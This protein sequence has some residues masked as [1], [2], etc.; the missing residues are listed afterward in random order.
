M[1]E[2]IYSMIQQYKE[3][4]K[5]FDEKFDKQYEELVLLQT[6]INRISDDTKKLK[7][8]TGNNYSKLEEQEKKP[9]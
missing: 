9:S 8:T 2:I 4:S 5:N 3:Y 6:E 1:Q 7:E